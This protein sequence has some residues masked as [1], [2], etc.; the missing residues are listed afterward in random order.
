MYVLKA[1]CLLAAVHL[2]FSSHHFNFSLSVFL[3]KDLFIQFPEAAT[4]HFSSPFNGQKLK[5]L[6]R[7]F[8]KAVAY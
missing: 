2:V 4:I 1:T 5:E 7:I 8:R 6:I 3:Q